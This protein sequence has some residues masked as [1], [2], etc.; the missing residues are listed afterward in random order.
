MNISFDFDETLDTIKGTEYAKE[1]MA[2][3]YNI[4]IHTR[5][6]PTF[7]KD[8]FRLAKQIGIPLENITFCGEVD[9]SYYLYSKD[10][11]F[12]LDDVPQEAPRTILFDKYFKEEC[13]MAIKK[14]LGMEGLHPTTKDMDEWEE[15]K[16]K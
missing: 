16:N 2:R 5:R 9:K 7:Y 15:F 10:Y 6:P 12:H 13:E 11:I 14:Y 4:L 8:V 1:L 3:G